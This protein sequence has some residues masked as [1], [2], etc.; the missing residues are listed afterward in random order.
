MVPSTT[1]NNSAKLCILIFNTVARTI[2]MKECMK[3]FSTCKNELD[4]LVADKGE[5]EAVL[6]TS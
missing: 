5:T 6:L 4:A 3:L 2:I 1:T